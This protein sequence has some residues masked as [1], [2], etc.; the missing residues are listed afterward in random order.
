MKIN[1]LSVALKFALLFSAG[2]VAGEEELT[3]DD[4]QGLHSIAAFESMDITNIRTTCL[5]RAAGTGG[6]LSVLAGRR[7]E[8]KACKIYATVR[9]PRGVKVGGVLVDF[10]GK[11]TNSAAVTYSLR[12]DNKTVVSGAPKKTGPFLV[13]GIANLATQAGR[14]CASSED[15]SVPIE[16]EVA[17]PSGSWD[18]L[19]LRFTNVHYC[20]Q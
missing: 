20:A 4:E 6:V 17:V 15:R 8:T 11:V 9:V 2:C 3:E 1:R 19:D 5:S 7:G 13:R 14:W 16:A 18:S 10:R 12:V